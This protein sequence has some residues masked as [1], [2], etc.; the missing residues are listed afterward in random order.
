MADIGKIAQ[1]LASERIPDSDKTEYW[2]QFNS[3]LPSGI[4]GI[5]PWYWSLEFPYHP[6]ETKNGSRP[7]GLI[8]TLQEPLD[9]RRLIRSAE[10]LK[11]VVKQAYDDPMHLSIYEV[12]IR[13]KREGKEPGKIP[14]LVGHLYGGATQHTL[15]R[16]DDAALT[17]LANYLTSPH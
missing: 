8:L 4:K 5:A 2:A 3:D 17:I 13:P 10:E 9:E 1:L 16:G 12:E 14:S 11:F 6:T 15:K 7:Q